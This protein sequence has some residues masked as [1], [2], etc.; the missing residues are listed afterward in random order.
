M[1]ENRGRFVP[2]V[3]VSLLW[4][5]F[6]YLKVSEAEDAVGWQEH[7]WEVLT[8]LDTLKETMIDQETG[9]RGY[10]LSAEPKVSRSLQKWSE[11]LRRD[12]YPVGHS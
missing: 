2:V 9:M 4:A 8:E 11:I 5:P 1:G 6:A 10:L 3:L 7:T 12:A